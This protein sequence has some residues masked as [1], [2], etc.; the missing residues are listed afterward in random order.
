MFQEIGAFALIMGW[1]SGYPV[2]AKIS[3]NF[4]EKNICT[5]EECERLLSF[6]NN[7]GPLFIIGTC[8]I[9]LFG[10]STIGVLLLIAHI[11]S[12]ITTG[13]LF[14]FWK[15]NSSTFTKYKTSK[16]DNKIQ[17]VSF[18]NLGEIL[19]YSIKSAIIT[20]VQIGGFVVLF[21]VIIV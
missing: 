19:G 9:G 18:S 15:R 12:S 1:L 16:S 13:F 7:S 10:N 14:R 6:T 8:G 4:R 3:M 17:N 11:F 5:K 21:S 20:V 2:G